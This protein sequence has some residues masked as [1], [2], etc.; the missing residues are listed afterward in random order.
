MAPEH[1]QVDS[2]TSWIIEPEADEW[3]LPRLNDLVGPITFQPGDSKIDAAGHQELAKHVRAAGFEI[4]ALDD[5]NFDWRWKGER[6][7]L[8][9]RLASWIK[10]VKGA[11]VAPS[12]LAAIGA[13][14]RRLTEA[15]TQTYYGSI[16]A[17]PFCWGNGAWRGSGKARSKFGAP[18]GSCWWSKDY[19]VDGHI[20]AEWFYL[21]GGFALLLFEDELRLFS[22]IGRAWLFEVEPD[23]YAV[24]NGYYRGNEQTRLYAQLLSRHFGVGYQPVSI[25]NGKTA[26]SWTGIRI[27]LYNG[28]F[29]VGP[30]AKLDSLD[31]ALCFGHRNEDFTIRS[32]D[33]GKVEEARKRQI[34]KRFLTTHENK[35]ADATKAQTSGSDR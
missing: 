21:R 17:G 11:E 34:V 22:D 35:N 2:S 23:V 33:A 8:P 1:S 14:G 25:N 12:V 30:Q 5:P 29:A 15:G 13:A 26:S 16:Y 27:G 28:S 32:L 3:A 18:S 4:P 7:T 31:T 6:G 10:K 9:K 24:A 19:A 20:Q